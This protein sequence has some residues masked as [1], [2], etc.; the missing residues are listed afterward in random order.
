[1]LADLS[2]VQVTAQ[3]G[4]L[5]AMMDALVNVTFGLADTDLD[6]TISRSEASAFAKAHLRETSPF[7]QTLGLRGGQGELAEAAVSAGVERV[8]S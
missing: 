5:G 4:L 8:F 3:L 2:V 7:G 6:G 1:M